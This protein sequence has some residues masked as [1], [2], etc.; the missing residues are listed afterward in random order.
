MAAKLDVNNVC[1]HCRSYLRVWNNI[2]MSVKSCTEDKQGLL[3]LN[4]ELGNYEFISHYSLDFQE[5][6][7]L[8]F[9]CPVCSANFTAADVNK[10]LARIRM[11]DKD[12]KEYDLYF[13]RLRGE[14]STF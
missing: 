4:P 6:E 9:F 8:D 10:N 1:P 7:C 3:L 5:M 2:I 13:S 14:H 12:Q 11:I